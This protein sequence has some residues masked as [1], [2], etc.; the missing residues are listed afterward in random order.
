ESGGRAEVAVY[1]ER[2]V[3]VEEVRVDA[4]AAA[5]RGVLSVDGRERGAQ[6]FVGALAVEQTRPEVYLPSEAPARAGV[7]ADFERPSGCREQLGRRARR[8]LRARKKAVEV[9]DV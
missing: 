9:R 6:E 5:A 7:A 1:L 3:G 8:Y 4:A 2:R